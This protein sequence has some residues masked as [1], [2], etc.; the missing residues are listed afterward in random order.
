[1]VYLQLWR[2]SKV[3]AIRLMGKGKP[4]EKIWVSDALASVMPLMEA[5]GV[6]LARAGSSGG[7]R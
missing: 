1:M 6:V 7:R 2:E 4:P 3:H 5:P